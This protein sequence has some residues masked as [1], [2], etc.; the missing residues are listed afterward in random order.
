MLLLVP[1]S[2]ETLDDVHGE[3]KALLERP[4]AFPCSRMRYSRSCANCSVNTIFSHGSQS[5]QRVF[6]SR[7]TSLKRAVDTSPE[8]CTRA[9]IRMYKRGELLRWV[10]RRGDHALKRG[11]E[12]R[13]VRQPFSWRAFLRWVHA[14]RKNLQ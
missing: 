2:D 13:Q 3:Y 6:V 4:Y 7:I 9:L 10:L 12:A 11:K 1:E 8:A 14:G 5:R